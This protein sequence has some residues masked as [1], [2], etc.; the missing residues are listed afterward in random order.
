MVAAAEENLR[1][2]IAA[3]KIHD[4]FRSIVAFQDSRFDMKIPREVQMFVD[5][6]PI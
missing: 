2:L 1:N 4:C 3:R 6:F 5:S